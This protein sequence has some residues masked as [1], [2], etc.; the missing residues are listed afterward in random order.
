MGVD[1]L[2]PGTRVMHRSFGLGTIRRATGAPHNL[3]VAVA[4]DSGVQKTL[5]ARFANLEVVDE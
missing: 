3:K 1:D 5:L 2:R 4:F